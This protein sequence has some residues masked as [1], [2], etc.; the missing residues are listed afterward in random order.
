MSKF[1]LFFLA[2]FMS[3]IVAALFF[4]GVAAFMLYQLVYM[5]NPDIRWWSASIPGLRYSMMTVLLMMLALGLRYKEYSELA[6][7]RQQ[8]L[9]RWLILFLILHFVAYTHA[10]NDFVHHQ[11]T[12]EF[13]KLVVIM[14]V[15]YKLITSEKALHA[16]LWT[17]IVGATYVGVVAYQTGRNAYGRVEGIGMVD[18]GGDGNHTAAALVPAAILLIYYAWTGS[19]KVKIA[20]L[21]CGAF[22]VNALVLINSRG[23]F[24]AAVAGAGYFVFY[25]IFSKHQ[26]A[27]Q[28]FAA[29]VMILVGLGGALYVTD[30]TF[31][32][33]MGT[34]QA[35]EDTGERGGAGRMAFWWATFPML[36][37]Y[38]AGMGIGGYQTVSEFYIDAGGTNYDPAN[39]VPHSSWF[40]VLG[41]LGYH[42]FLVFALMIFSVFRISRKAKA[43]VLREENIGAYFHLLVIEAGLLAYLVAA[44]FIDRARAEVLYWFLLFGAAAANVYYLQ[45]QETLQAKRH[46]NLNRQLGRE[47][48]P[49]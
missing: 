31:W 39:R 46:R 48:E 1:G 47:P 16:V 44:S 23:A 22:I 37:D 35:D 2:V 9:F 26:R 33:R 27:G 14:M 3:G 7:W 38:P 13:T 42:G 25:M 8:P 24:L 12:V 40:Q 32:E 28:R 34:L 6:P 20:S 18:T 21:F 45:Y 11:F 30:D 15:A 19:L 5:M 4:H 49:T 41:D 29:I 43:Y 17:Y 36:S 10:L